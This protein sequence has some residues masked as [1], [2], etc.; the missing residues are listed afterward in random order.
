LVILL[1]YACGLMYKAA[2]RAF[3]TMFDR[4]PANEFG[5]VVYFYSQKLGVLPVQS[6]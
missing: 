5:L 4:K 6:F 1:A 2:E 3:S